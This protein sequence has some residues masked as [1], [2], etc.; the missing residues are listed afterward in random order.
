MID[1]AKGCCATTPAYCSTLAS[2]STILKGVLV[3]LPP[4]PQ[5]AGKF[6]HIFRDHDP[7]G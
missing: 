6:R 2:P 4:S 3:R 1:E 7:Y 5:S